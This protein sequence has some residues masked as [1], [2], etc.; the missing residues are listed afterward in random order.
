MV[1]ADSAGM[2][3]IDHAE[4]VLTEVTPV[5]VARH[6]VL[7]AEVRAGLGDARVQ[8][9]KAAWDRLVPCLDALAGLSGAELPPISAAA[10]Y[11]PTVT[12]RAIVAP[13]PLTSR[14]SDG[15]V[16]FLAG[17]ITD[18]PDWQAT[19]IE[20]LAHDHVVLL[21]PRRPTFD[22]ADP[23]AA[24][25]QVR[26]EY[27]H[28]WHEQLSFMLFWFPASPSV[29]PIAMLELGEALARPELPIVVG[30][31]PNYP[32]YQDLVRQCGAARPNLVVRNTLRDVVVDLQTMLRW[33]P[34]LPES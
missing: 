12:F 2:G 22:A 24:D 30:A 34:D 33:G 29:Q 17:G 1:T 3:D 7:L 16:V 20:A 27:G 28:R 11:P 23:A 14:L 8:R 25:V 19:A 32:R 4:M 26:W 15:P 5:L 31:E 13:E 9:R 21:N 10:P 6:A 18:C